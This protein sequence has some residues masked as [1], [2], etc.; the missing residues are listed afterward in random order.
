MESLNYILYKEYIFK[1]NYLI[2]FDWGFIV[3]FRGVIVMSDGF[4]IEDIFLDNLI[5]NYY[6]IFGGYLEK[7]NGV[8]FFLF[9]YFI[10]NYFY[11]II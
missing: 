1:D 4:F 3:D 10:N 5:L 6:F 11:W 8:F 9:C 7:L 2:K